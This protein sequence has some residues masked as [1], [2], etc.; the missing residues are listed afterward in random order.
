MS[1]QPNFP[2]PANYPGQQPYPPQQPPQPQPF[3]GQPMQ[4]G[5]GYGPPPGGPTSPFGADTSW[6]PSTPPPSGGGGN[7]GRTALVI[8]TLVVVVG[9][10]VAGWLITRDAEDKAI[11]TLST[12]NVS[13]PD[14]TS[15]DV[16][17]PQVTVAP[18]TI[19]DLTGTTLPEVLTTIPGIGEPSATTVPTETAPPTTLPAPPAATNLFEGTQTSDVI[20]AIAAARAASPLRILDVNLYTEY[21]FADVQDPNTPANIDEFGW[22]DGTVGPSSPVQL[23]G[24][25]DL[26]ANLFSDSDVNWN[27]IP[28]L[29]GAAL[30]QIPIEGANVTHVNISRNL[31]FS[32]DIQIRVFVD[33]TRTSG[34]LDA[35]SQ[36]NILTVNQG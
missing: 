34:Y 24:D 16:T 20:A 1:D 13:I 3:G 33:G 7:G 30:A 11:D 29:V 2:G 26:E 10:S 27:A 9:L 21:A 32:A 22:R 25:G 36:G 12:L 23:S 31:P 17:R 8:I 5:T 35:D 14:I 28:G 6:M 15:P 19:P 18:V 4:P